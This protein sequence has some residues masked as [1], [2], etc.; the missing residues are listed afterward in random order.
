MVCGVVATMSH[1]RGTT[2]SVSAFPNPG[3]RAGEC[4]TWL[5]LR[6]RRWVFRRLG[7]HLREVR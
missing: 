6:E 1:L 3:R 5:A 4:H 2:E 7:V